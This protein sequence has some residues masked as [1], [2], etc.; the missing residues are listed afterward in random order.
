MVCFIGRCITNGDCNQRELSEEG[1]SVTTISH[2]L[3]IA[4]SVFCHVWKEGN[5]NVVRYSFN[6]NCN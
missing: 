2:Y 6:G 1:G 5:K 3:T 4:I